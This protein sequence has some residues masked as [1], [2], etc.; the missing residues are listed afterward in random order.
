M[1]L[2][3]RG[4]LIDYSK[5]EA[6]EC[7]ET[8]PE[9]SFE[10]EFQDPSK[11]DHNCRA[12]HPPPGELDGMAS[13]SAHGHSTSECAHDHEHSHT[14]GDHSHHSHTE[15]SPAKTHVEDV[16]GDAQIQASEREGESG[17]VSPEWFSKEANLPFNVE[18]LVDAKIRGED[19]TA[20]ET[21]H[22]LNLTSIPL[23]S[24]TKRR[25]HIHKAGLCG[26]A[27]VQGKKVYEWEQSFEE[28][29][30]FV[31]IPPSIK[32]ASPRSSRVSQH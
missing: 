21:S 15:I 29:N 27:A 11:H 17:M 1:P 13:N 16:A 30:I 26:A 19:T 4:G 24:S 5:F 20:M 3:L 22:N 28:V 2:R 32:V 7:S 8:P 18:E 31:T 25:P 14:A 10:E 12:Y 23:Q 9:S 6:L